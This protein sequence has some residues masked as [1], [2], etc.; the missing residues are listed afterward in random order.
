MAKK[1]ISPTAAYATCDLFAAFVILRAY[2]N[3][4]FEQWHDIA[5][6]VIARV[7]NVVEA[8][9]LVKEYIGQYD[10]GGG[11]WGPDSGVVFMWGGKRYADISYNG[12][13]WRP[14]GEM[15][16]PALLEYKGG[17]VQ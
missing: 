7:A 5:P 17:P 1:P 4:D 16:T 13:I 11:N 9:D 15:S 2:G 6:L 10:L 8:V 12:R 14:S 3:P